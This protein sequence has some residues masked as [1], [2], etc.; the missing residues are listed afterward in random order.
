MHLDL[1]GHDFCDS[2]GAMAKISKIPILGK[3][4]IHIGYGIQEHIVDTILKDVPSSTY[5]LITDTNIA[6]C[7]HVDILE[8]H[9]NRAFETKYS[10]CRLL[11]YCV[12]PGELSKSRS[13]KANVEDWLLQQ[14]CTRDTVII[15]LGG[16]VIGDMIGYVAATFMRGVRYIQVPTTLLA[17]VDS[18]IGGKTAI[19]TPMGK[20]LVGAFW[21]PQKNFIELSFLET[22]PEREFLNG[23]AEVIKTAAIWCE[24]EFS[25][26]ESVN[27]AF[28]NAIS[29][30]NPESGRIDLSEIQE[31]IFAIVEGSVRTKAEVVTKDEREGGLRNILNF[32][33]SI[34]HAFEALL[35]PYILHGECVSI[36]MVLEAELSRFLGYLD[37]SA[38]ARLISCLKMY[39]LPTTIDDSLV[40]ERSNNIF[41][42]VDDLLKI[43]AVDKKNSGAQKRV[44]L[45][46]AIGQTYE[47]KATSVSDDDLRIILSDHISVGDYSKVPQKFTV[48]PPGSKSVSNR[49]LILAALGSGSCEIENL[50]HSDD[51]NYMLE[52][53]EQFKCARIKRLRGGRVICVDGGSGIISAPS[54]PVYLGNSGTSARFLTALACLA[55]ESSNASHTILTGNERMQERPIGPLVK[56]LR[57]AGSEIFYTKNEGSLPLKISASNQ[58]NFLRGGRIE[59]AATVSSQYVSAILLCAPYAASPVTLVIVDGK[60]ISELYIDMTIQM[61]A[62][63]GV[64]VRKE[65]DAYVYHIPKGIYQNPK[66]YIVECDAS[67]ATYPLALAAL[68]GRT[69]TVSNMGSESLQGDAR[70][71]PCVLEKMGCSVTQTLTSTTVQ[72]PQNGI[73][74]GIESIDMESMT[75][76]FLTAAA[77]AAVAE[78]KTRIYG[79]AN[80][81]VKECN[82]LEA[83]RKELT[84]FGVECEEH[85]DGL[86]INGLAA[87]KPLSPALLKSYDD[88]RIAM[89]LSLLALLTDSPVII[90]DRRCV[91]KTWPGWWDFIHSIGVELK[92]IQ[93]P[94]KPPK[95][96]V[97]EKSIILI[98]MRGAGKTTMGKWVASSLGWSFIDLDHCIQ[99][100]HGNISQ[101]VESKGWEEFRRLET[102]YLRDFLK[103]KSE[104]FVISC[105]GGIVESQEARELLL[106]F[107]KIGGNVVHVHRKIEDIDAY[108]SE[109]KGRP[110]LAEKTVKL[111]QRRKPLYEQCSNWFYC[112]G[113]IETMEDKRGVLRSLSKILAHIIEPQ[114]MKLDAT[115]SYFISLTYSNLRQAESIAVITEGVHAV[116]LRVDLL[117]SQSID[118]V[119]D[120]IGYLR[121]RTT[122]PIIFTV[123]TKSQGG[124][125]SDDAHDE[126]LRLNL[127][128]IK[129]GIEYIDVELSQPSSIQQELF[130]N[131]RETFIISS[132]HD[133]Q[134]KIEWG[135]AWEPFYF[136]AC[137]VGDIVKFVGFANSFEDNLKLERFREAHLSPQCKPLICLNMG[138][139][140]QLSRV[141]N[142]Y[143]TPVTHEALPYAAAPGQLSIC[144]INKL[145]HAI[146]D[147]PAKEFFVCGEPIGHSQS[148]NLHNAGFAALGLPHLYGKFET[149]TAS[150]VFNRIRKLG[151]KFGGCSVTI[152]LKTD[153]M[154]YLD[155]VSPEAEAI[156]AVN[157][158]YRSGSGSLHGTNTDWIGIVQ[159]FQ[160]FGLMLGR[161][162]S[163]LILGAGGTSQ[164][165]IYAFHAMKFKTIYVLNRTRQNAEKVLARFGPEYNVHLLEETEP[166]P[167]V[168][169]V[170]GCVP[171]DR[172]L[173]TDVM[174][175]IKD[176]MA[177][178]TSGGY[179]LEAA[180]K[181][182]ITPLMK[183]GMSLNWVVI[184]GR[185]LLVLQ[186]LEQFRIWNGSIASCASTAAVL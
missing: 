174:T 151:E 171:G 56:S 75:D 125:F 98:G 112:S 97:N 68:T 36:G 133:S 32:G 74:H 87:T 92:G 67:S 172:E 72:G 82:R 159:S 175:R 115:R 180:Y 89:S 134:G 156:G 152:P 50:L 23:M 11:K 181:P 138:Y 80:Q 142:T 35:T 140:G 2:S 160:K 45:L 85:D 29:K 165:A 59:L 4:T 182:D 33:H 7:K 131:R 120:Q 164:A 5:V 132:H 54:Q 69:C 121:M 102:C 150:N 37:P 170:M 173:P 114:R 161:G 83:M 15:A 144:Q 78:G 100:D 185:E 124:Q 177:L 116:E 110:L 38:V 146:G 60:P 178:N 149:S 76:A 20:N 65:P 28:M 117:E 119:S 63:F 34:G 27:S 44:T 179:L 42:P 168:K 186:G 155:Q 108:L 135:P 183:I 118:F 154:Q 95:T 128:A 73:L 143:L 88:H 79:I 66:N 43:M 3:E 157:T 31:T 81:R 111:Y 126:Y 104:R 62:A 99:D 8:N 84:K 148:P 40:R 141:L 162:Q 18:S 64:H 26:L 158:I 130:N 167:V 25:R 169:A 21:H 10:N 166:L 93:A 136:D 49:V 71:A 6:K 127:H 46:R 105:G 13:T 52:A 24:E 163:A 17:M 103:S 137:R 19:D 12:A 90:E 53:I 109:D 139:K 153:V 96:I 9:F 107:V 47:P 57:L 106:S 14:G 113:S 94:M 41:C 30:R 58:D 16:G 129:M 22:L 39:K 55:R 91:E 61:M 122:L 123:R 51:T 86:F 77:V 184:P 147:L 48:S 101:F 145:R 1:D 70:F 176:I